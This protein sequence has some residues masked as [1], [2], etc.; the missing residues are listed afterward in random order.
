[1]LDNT[2]IYL[3]SI[4]CQEHILSTFEYSCHS[5]LKPGSNYVFARYKTFTSIF[6]LYTVNS[7]WKRSFLCVLGLNNPRNVAAILSPGRD[8]G[9]DY[10]ALC[11][12]SS[13]EHTRLIL[14]TIH[15][16]NISKFYPLNFNLKCHSRNHNHLTFFV[17]T[18][19]GICAG[20]FWSWSWGGASCRYQQS[21]VTAWL[22]FHWTIRAHLRRFIGSSSSGEGQGHMDQLFWSRN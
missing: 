13:S 19:A 18:Y 8:P 20:L 4:Q 3:P 2:T 21:H 11:K 15:R 12:S 14:N 7:V 6:E 9:T 22:Q 10:W 1:M 5:W 16:D 17:Q